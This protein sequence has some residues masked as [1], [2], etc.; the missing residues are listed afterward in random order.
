MDQYL[1]ELNPLYIQMLILAKL[2]K[3]M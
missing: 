3:I 2:T 1:E